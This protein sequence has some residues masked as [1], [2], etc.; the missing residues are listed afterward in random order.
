MFAALSCFSCSSESEEV[1]FLADPVF[2]NLFFSDSTE[3]KEIRTIAGAYSYS[4]KF[5]EYD[6]ITNNKEE[7]AV[8][9]VPALKHALINGSH[10]ILSPLISSLV[11]YSSSAAGENEDPVISLLKNYPIEKV[12]FWLSEPGIAD[13]LYYRI[14]RNETQGWYDA[15]R[16]GG[17]YKSGNTAFIYIENDEKGESNAV[18]FSQGTELSG[19]GPAELFTISK[20]ASVKILRDTL[21]QMISRIGEES[22]LGVYA[23]LKT[24]DIIKL[25][26]DLGLFVICEQAEWLITNKNGSFG[27]VKENLPVVFERV[28]KKI[29]EITAPEFEEYAAITEEVMVIPDQ[30]EF[31]VIQ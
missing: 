15:G 22:V 17:T 21:N 26:R 23:G 18:S 2:T 4:L 27:T 12:V 14:V 25:A 13:D 5:I 19:A 8:E 20:N 16:F 11:L 9:A 3:R 6:V 1:V 7:T 31:M 10:I 28:F 30:I 24:A 29:N